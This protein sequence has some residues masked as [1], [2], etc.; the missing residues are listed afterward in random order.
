MSAPARQFNPSPARESI[1]SKM[2][3]IKPICESARYLTIWSVL[4]AVIYFILDVIIEKKIKKVAYD[5][6]IKTPTFYEKYDFNLF[7]K[8]V[9]S[10]MGYNSSF[11]YIK[12]GLEIFLLPLVIYFYNYACMRNMEYINYTILVIYLIIFISKMNVLFQTNSNVNN[13]VSKSYM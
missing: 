7:L 3:K 12:F 4:T 5:I 1:F 10:I 8:H 6:Y 11:K 13:E 9:Y 2:F